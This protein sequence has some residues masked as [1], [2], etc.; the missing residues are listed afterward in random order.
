MVLETSRRNASITESGLLVEKWGNI[1]HDQ[2]QR[3]REI[4]C[5]NIRRLVHYLIVSEVH[6]FRE[7]SET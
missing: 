5:G 4:L 7:T 2:K 1:F 3:L 6:S